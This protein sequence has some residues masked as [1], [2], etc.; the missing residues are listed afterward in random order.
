MFGERFRR[1]MRDSIQFSKRLKG[2]PIVEA[3]NLKQEIMSNK[4]I[5]IDKILIKYNK[6]I[7]A[8]NEM[9]HGSIYIKYRNMILS[10][11]LDTYLKI[12][13]VD[14]LYLSFHIN[15]EDLKKLTYK[16]IV[17]YTNLESQN[18]LI[19]HDIDEIEDVLQKL[20]LKMYNT[21]LDNV[22]KR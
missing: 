9:C 1:K 11:L 22:L 10:E 14:E 6:K 18:Y 13:K 21:N 4:K 19:S 16:D 20:F 2:E 7:K 12:K 5:K 15:Y 8:S 3:E 17:K